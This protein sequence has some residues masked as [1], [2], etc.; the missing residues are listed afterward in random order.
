MT[1]TGPNPTSSPANFPQ[2]QVTPP[3]KRRRWPWILVG[4]LGTFVVLG[5]GC[6]A[7]IGGAAKQVADS[8]AKQ[9]EVAA[10]GGVS[11]GIGSQD[12]TADVG[13]PTMA[14]PDA[15]GV[16]YVQIPVTNHS[17]GRSDY[18]ID[19]AIESADGATQLGTAFASV[20]G[21]EAGQTTTTQAM[22]TDADSFPA[23][24]IVRITTVQRTASV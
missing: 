14:A 10:E 21:L 15:I 8:A 17:S 16:V 23:D 1:M 24:A 11:N 20:Q 22:V 2:F 3:K 19:V 18:F 7:L 5:G 9:A 13:T 4:V 12:A 6:A